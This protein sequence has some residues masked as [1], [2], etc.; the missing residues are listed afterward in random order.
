MEHEKAQKLWFLLNG[1]DRNIPSELRFFNVDKLKYP[2]FYLLFWNEK[3]DINQIRKIALK[4]HKRTNYFQSIA[5]IDII[6]NL[7]LTDSKKSNIDV[8]KQNQIIDQFLLE[9]PS[10]SR[11]KNGD[12]DLEKIDLT[13]HDYSPP[14]S[15]TY[16]VIL[17]KQQKYKQAIEI[18]EKLIL[19]KPEKSLYFAFQISELKKYK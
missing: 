2:F 12:A 18:Y 6:S 4:S 9:L 19:S 5:D 15:E 3:F 16:A 11:I 7:N 14:I 1:F 17:Q 13:E 8:A 10:I